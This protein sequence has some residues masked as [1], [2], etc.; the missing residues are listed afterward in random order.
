MT[1]KGISMTSIK[2]QGFPFIAGNL[3]KRSF[4]NTV[5]GARL[6]FG[7]FYG[8][9]GPVLFTTKEFKRGTTQDFQNSRPEH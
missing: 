7:G 6:G 5:C 8:V 4:F 1:S 2:I 9:E 3:W